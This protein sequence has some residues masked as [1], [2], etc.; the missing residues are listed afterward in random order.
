M[1]KYDYTP[2]DSLA[3]AGMVF[4]AAID[5]RTLGVPYSVARQLEIEDMY[6]ADRSRKPRAETFSAIM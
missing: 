1:A 6:K 4:S 3:I 2:S 5:W